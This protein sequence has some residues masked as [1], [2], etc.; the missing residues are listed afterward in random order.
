MPMNPLTRALVG[1]AV[2]LLAPALAGAAEPNAALAY[3]KAFHFMPRLNQNEIKVISEWKT[4]KLEDLRPLVG[5]APAWHLYLHRAAKIKACDWGPDHDE[6]GIYHL[7]PHL[8]KGRML[9]RL[10]LA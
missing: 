4:A 8:D 6:D 9:A 5:E 1:A 2:C 10:A 3:W 7:L